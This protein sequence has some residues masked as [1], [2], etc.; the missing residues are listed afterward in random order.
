MYKLLL[1][2]FITTTIFAQDITIEWLEKQPTS[3]A[4]DFYIWRYLSY[5]ITPEQANKALSQV[6][7]LNNKIFYRYITKSK[8]PLLKE[9]KTCKRAKTQFLLQKEDYCIEAGL[10]IY[11]ATK[12]SK[13]DLRKVI[14][15]VQKEYPFYAKNLL[16]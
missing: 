10:S 15:K 12:L 1:T 5:D 14:Q 11:D 16:Y 9:Y 4:K 2:V 6:K 3:Y 8:D 7:Q 13:N